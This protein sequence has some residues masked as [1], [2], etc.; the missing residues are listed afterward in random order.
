[1]RRLLTL[2]LLWPAL[3]SAT[4]PMCV[5]TQCNFSITAGSA[6]VGDGATFNVSGPGF[7][8]SGGWGT[9]GSPF[10]EGFSDISPGVPFNIQ[11][12]ENCDGEFSMSVGWNGGG[13]STGAGFNEP[14]G[15][16]S[17][18]T[19]P[20]SI[21]GAGVYKAGFSLFGS[22]DGD[23]CLPVAC[24][25][26]VLVQG[27]GIATMNIIPEG[28][29]LFEVASTTVTFGAPEPSTASLLL[30]AF[31]GLAVLGRRRRPGATL[32]A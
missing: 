8:A 15:E 30:I 18:A 13:A 12:G 31:T 32:L 26:S 11:W 21:T 28:N 20:I 4:D 27:T 1:M 23:G 22:V 6:F 7:T 24:N 3:A 19:S 9:T 10:P 17:F 25:E 2:L 29:G 14:C 16:G 5:D